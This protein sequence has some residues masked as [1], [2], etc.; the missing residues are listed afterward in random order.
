[1][2]TKEKKRENKTK[3]NESRIVISDVQLLKRSLY[4][5]VSVDYFVVFVCECVCAGAKFIGLLYHIGVIVLYLLVGRVDITVT[6][7]Y[8]RFTTELD[9]HQRATGHL[10]RY[11]R[12]C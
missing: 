2:F 1:M 5:F 3:A 11:V 9:L 8:F 10:M 7:R 6:L 4:I 12:T